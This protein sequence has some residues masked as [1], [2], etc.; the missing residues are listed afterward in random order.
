M[1]FDERLEFLFRSSESLHASCQELHASARDLRE[2]VA[3]HTRQLEIDAQNI[4]ALANIAAAHQARL[5]D[6]EDQ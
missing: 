6:L 4:R 2:T 5:D 1:T 3:E